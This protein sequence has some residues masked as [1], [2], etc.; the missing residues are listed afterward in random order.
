MQTLYGFNVPLQVFYETSAHLCQVWLLTVCTSYHS[1]AHPA[2]S[3]EFFKAYF[4]CHVLSDT[5]FHMPFHTLPYQIN[6][7]FLFH[8]TCSNRSIYSAYL[9]FW[10]AVFISVFSTKLKISYP[11]QDLSK[12]HHLYLLWPYKESNL[13]PAQRLTKRCIISSTLLLRHPYLRW[14]TACTVR[15]RGVPRTDIAHISHLRAPFKLSVDI[16]EHLR[17]QKH[18]LQLTYF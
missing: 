18:F 16:Q 15:A 4:N 1:F 12:H 9:I 14:M 11:F 2:F 13:N 8:S 5:S 6:H 10:L 7:F 17:N 3:P